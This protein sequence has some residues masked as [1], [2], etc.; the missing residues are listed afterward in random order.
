VDHGNTAFDD[1]VKSAVAVECDE[2][3]LRGRLAKMSRCTSNRR[4]A[5]EGDPLNLV[6]IGEFATI[7]GGFGARWDETEAINIRS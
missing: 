5:A 1:L 4:S 7:L 2:T 3:D 6:A